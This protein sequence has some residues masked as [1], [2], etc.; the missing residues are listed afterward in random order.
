MSDLILANQ[1]PFAGSLSSLL[2]QS[3][4]L[5]QG[6]HLPR[7]GKKYPAE[8][9]SLRARRSRSW[10]AGRTGAHSAGYCGVSVVVMSW[11][12]IRPPLLHEAWAI[13]VAGSTVRPKKSPMKLVLPL[14]VFGVTR[15]FGVKFAAKFLE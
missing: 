9:A 15:A 14:M 1:G 4:N 12:L 3:F 7:I 5:I 13:P 11:P 10:F 2:S 6:P 8:G